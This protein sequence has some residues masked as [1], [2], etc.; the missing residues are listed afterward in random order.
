[1]RKT[2]VSFLLSMSII[3]C[4]SKD[5]FS[6]K[7]VAPADYSKK[8][9]YRPEIEKYVSYLG[10]NYQDP[11]EFVLR[12]FDS[13][14][15][16]ILAERDHREMTQWNFIYDLIKDP[17]FNEKVGYLFTEYHSINYQEELDAFLGAETLEEQKIKN[18]LHNFVI[19]PEGWV[20]NNIFEFMKRFYSL[21]KTLD[22]GH[23]IKWY[24]S[25]IPW[26]WQG[27]TQSEYEAQ[28]D[29]TIGVRDEVMAARIRTVY[30]TKILPSDSPRKKVLVVMNTRHAFRTPGA[31]NGD[32]FQENV[33]S[34]L[35]KWYPTKGRVGYVMF[36]YLSLVKPDPNSKPIETPVQEGMWDAAFAV[37][38]NTPRAVSFENSPFGED[39]FDYLGNR[40]MNLKFK[41]VFDGMLFYTPLREQLVQ[42]NIPGFYSEQFKHEVR[43]R[44][45]PKPQTEGETYLDSLEKTWAERV[46]HPERFES[47]KNFPD[48]ISQNIDKW[49]IH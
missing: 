49:L 24:A 2:V 6:L 12:L 41:D 46:Q 27:M 26:K 8:E 30:M 37:F 43:Q 1:M 44:P 32:L 15:I 28:W 38:G 34:M 18:L 22:Q 33:G 40:K 7:G 9:D 31:V 14:D 23:Q 5:S 36:N 20:N 45:M 3:S 35:N 16:V 29:S 11:V 39:I 21:N 10:A 48:T 4:G 19:W 13:K 47:R 42:D 25:D 17:R